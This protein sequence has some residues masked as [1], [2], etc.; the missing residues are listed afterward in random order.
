MCSLLD[1]LEVL[2]LGLIFLLGLVLLLPQSVQKL[3]RL[4]QYLWNQ[5]IIVEVLYEEDPPVK[6]EVVIGNL[7]YIGNKVLI[8]KV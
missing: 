5:G 8:L 7:V 1:D 2:K 6:L 3:M 4:R